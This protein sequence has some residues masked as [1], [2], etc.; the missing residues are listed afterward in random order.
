MPLFE[1]FAEFLTNA[2]NYLGEF[3]D[4]GAYFTYLW[5]SFVALLENFW[6]VFTGFFT[7]L[8]R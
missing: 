5:E 3:N 8:F 4:I 7:G 2:F 6:A 1:E